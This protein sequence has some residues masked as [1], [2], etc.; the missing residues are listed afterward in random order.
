MA[1]MTT[2]MMRR[3]MMRRNSVFIGGIRQKL[4]MMASHGSEESL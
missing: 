4:V 3:M 1:M 2:M